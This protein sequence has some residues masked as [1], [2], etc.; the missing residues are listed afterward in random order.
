MNFSKVVFYWL[1]FACSRSFASDEFPYDGVNGSP[2]RALRQ[3]MTSKD[4]TS[5]VATNIRHRLESLQRSEGRSD[6]QMADEIVGYA[7]SHLELGD[8]DNSPVSLN[9]NLLNAFKS[10]DKDKKR[11]VSLI[12]AASEKASDKVKKKYSVVDVDHSLVGFEKRRSPTASVRKLSGRHS[13]QS[14]AAG[15]LQPHCIVSQCGKS[16]GV[17][18]F[19]KHKKT[20]SYGMSPEKVVENKQTSTLF[21]TKKTVDD[22]YDDLK[23]SRT[24]SLDFIG[25]YSSK[26]SLLIDST[27][28]P[29]LV[30]QRDQQDLPGKITLVRLTKLKPDYKTV[31]SFGRPLVV[32]V[33]IFDDMMRQG[34]PLDVVEANCSMVDITKQV[35]DH[36]NSE[37]VKHGFENGKLPGSVYGVK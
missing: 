18:A 26:S 32:S 7:C 15:T 27:Q 19:G 14:F 29:L 17:L 10:P 28:F 1:M 9:N 33:S 13:M 35:E 24:R 4:I 36:F 16:L 37:I 30:A 12:E 11:A 31:E 21:A 5:P 6:R 20:V 22:L 34:T 2:V 25:S 3:A 8:F 23:V